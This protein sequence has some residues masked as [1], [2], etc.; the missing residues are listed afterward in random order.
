MAKFLNTTGIT[1]YLEDLIK[2]SSERLIL[3]SPYLK[4]SSRIKELLEDK[5]R[6]KIDI[7][8]I[9]GKSELAPN[10]ASWLKTLDYVRTSFCENLHAKCYMSED[11]CII[12]SLNLY[13][14]SQVNN[15]EM[16][17]YISKN[18]DPELYRDAYEEAQ[19]LIRVSDEVRIAVDKVLPKDEPA[20][21][22]Q[23]FD[24]L[25]NTRLA[26]ELKIKKSELEEILV[27]KG[28][29]VK[30]DK[31]FELTA[32]GKAVGAVSLDGRFGSYIL[33]PSD[34]DPRV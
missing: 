24:K 29:V 7:R 26:S 13:E 27:S 30:D 14:F 18:D 17:V 19:R 16:G 12:S 21:P 22:A 6:L 15:N 8:I 10:E 1:Y 2:G 4:L 32:K 25:T 28:Y 5:N 33:W 9:Y 3:I 23:S 31:I 20:E 34:F 11:S